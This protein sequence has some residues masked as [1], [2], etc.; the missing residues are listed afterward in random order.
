MTV[1][2]NATI[3]STFNGVLENTIPVSVTATANGPTNPNIDFYMLLDSSPSMAIAATAAGIATMVDNT[4][5]QCDFAPY[6]GSNCGCGFACHESNP[7]AESHYIPVG[8]GSTVCKGPTQITGG[9]GSPPSIAL[10]GTSQTVTG[11]NH[12]SS[13]NSKLQSFGNRQ[14][15]YRCRYRYTDVYGS[16]RHGF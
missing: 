4:Q 1:N 5:G 14:P 8:T 16:D 15:E 9:T 12:A 2:A 10:G 6:G 11:T 7:G 13:F 3:N